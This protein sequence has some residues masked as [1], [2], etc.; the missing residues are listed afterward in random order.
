MI[1]QSFINHDYILHNT[2]TSRKV[3]SKKREKKVKFFLEIG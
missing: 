1:T 2:E 3:K